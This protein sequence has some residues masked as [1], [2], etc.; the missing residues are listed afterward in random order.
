[1]DFGGIYKNCLKYVL[2]I[3]TPDAFG[4]DFVIAVIWAGLGNRP[5]LTPCDNASWGGYTVL[6]RAY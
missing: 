4:V 2:E 6:K 5:R 1:M 3:I